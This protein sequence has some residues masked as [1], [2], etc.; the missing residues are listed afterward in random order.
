M[1][2]CLYW[3]TKDLR[4]NDNLALH[5]AQQNDKLLCVYVIDEKWFAN[6]KYQSKPLGNVRWSFLQSCLNDFNKQLLALGQQLYI[7]YGDTI[8][9]LTH[10]CKSYKINNLVTTRLPGSYEQQNITKLQ[11]LLP[12][13]SIN[14]VEQFTLFNSQSL[15]FEIEQLPESFSRFRKLMAN[16]EAPLTLPKVTSLPTTFC[17]M[18]S[19]T[20]FRPSWVPQ[21]NS[22]HNKG[23][24][25]FDGG[26]QQGQKQLKQ[27]L[28][29]P[30]ALNYKKVRNEL[31]GW[32]NSSKFSPWLGY[33]CISP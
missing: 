8:T 9:T 30:A 28:S 4:I 33:G 19:P 7:V 17:N 23:G 10:L 5:L 20:L 6:T 31:T 25:L 24:Y 2:H 13:L 14:Q 27:Y 1:K 15:S 32:L 22:L 26:E 12:A 29:S 3:V 16:I 21:I 11:G 18:P